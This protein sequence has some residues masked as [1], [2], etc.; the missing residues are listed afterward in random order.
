MARY[1]VHVFR[2]QHTCLQ[3]EIHHLLVVNQATG[4]QEI[5][6]IY[7]VDIQ[8]FFVCTVHCS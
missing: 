1:N 8:L 2:C 5:D 7:S 3:H 6:I 4:C